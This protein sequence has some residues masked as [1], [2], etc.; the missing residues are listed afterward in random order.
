MGETEET[1]KR[2]LISAFEDACKAMKEAEIEIQRLRGIVTV[3]RQL[4]HDF[5][6]SC[7]INKPKCSACQLLELTHND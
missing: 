5:P 4:A 6:C 3:A 7:W 2:A 1:Q